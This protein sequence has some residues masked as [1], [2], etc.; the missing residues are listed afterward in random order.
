M[1]TDVLIIGAGGAGL[2][3]ALSAK[4]N[5][6]NVLVVSKSFPTHS[7]TCQAQ[8]GINAVINKKDS[9]QSHRNDTYK[10][11]HKLGNQTIIETLCSQGEAT[12]KW[13]DEL[14]V[15][16]SRN[17]E[18]RI[19]QR[20]F[21]GASF[22]R[23]CY[24]SDYTGLKILH[25]LYDTCIKEN[26]SFLNEH[27]LLNLIRE[28]NQVIGATFLDINTGEVKALY[29]KTVILASGGY[30]GIYSGFNTNSSATTGD[31]IAAALR[32]GATLSNME[33]V[34]FH[35]TA[36]EGSNVLVSESARGEGGYL[37]DENGERFVDELQPRDVVARAIYEKLHQDKKVYLD[38]RHLGLEKINETMPQERRLAMEFA[39]V[40]LESDLL[41]INPAAHYCM[42]GIL[43]DNH[44]QSSIKNL[45]ACG[46]CSQS[47][48]HGA[49]RLG[50]NSL[51]E[52]I[53]FGKMAG[54]H[55]AEKAKTIETQTY[56]EHHQL[57]HDKNFIENL[58]HYPNQIDFYDKK[59]CMGKIFFKNVGLFRNDMNMKAVHS[60]I[61]QWQK[62]LPLMGIGDKSR[63][64]NKNL[65]DFLEF[66][67]MLELSETVVSSALSRCES[68]GAHYRTDYPNESEAYEKNSV[69]HKTDDAITVM[70]K[71]VL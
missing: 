19:A 44:S 28:K 4:K 11:S 3:A 71:D 10:S 2:S 9:I 69:V 46:E 53:T 67:N 34:Q 37:I 55:A 25:T 6:A 47:N 48:V 64:Y 31:G 50:G 15:P 32:A 65:V 20:K 61:K 1:R 8:G 26:I 40:K 36:M 57:I 58:F 27:L 22:N 39:N 41:A 63:H 24:S 68:R 49:N 43:V 70:F 13:L 60:Q 5:H 7:Q 56:S 38:L 35:P 33:F 45:Y 59:A 14:G 23:T 51:L 21:G 30:T 62:E 29:A 52:I 16:F 66:Q 17:A 18:N 42:G 12:I 54:K